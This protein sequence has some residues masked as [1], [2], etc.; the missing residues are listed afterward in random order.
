[1]TQ[2]SSKN[3][4]PKPLVLIILEGWGVAPFHPG[5]AISEAQPAYFNYLLSHYP[6]MTLEAS[7]PAVG[8]VAGQPVTSEDGYALI[9]SGRPRLS[10]QRLVDEHLAKGQ[11]ASA[12]ALLEAFARP[13]RRVHLIGSLSPA[14]REAVPAHLEALIEAVS[15]LGAGEIVLHAILDGR[16]AAP[17]AGRGALAGWEERL[18]GANGRIGSLSGSFYALDP[19]RNPDRLAR[20][21]EAIAFGRGNQAEAAMPIIEENYAKKI[22]DEEFPPTVISGAQPAGIAAADAVIFFNFHALPMQGLAS[23]L[24]AVLPESVARLS[25]VEYGVPGFLPL[26]GAPADQPCLGSLLA[27]AGLRQLRISDSEGFPGVTAFLD[28]GRRQLPG[29]AD[30]QIIPTPVLDDYRSEPGV[31]NSEIAK[32]TVKA[33]EEKK[34]DLIAVSFASIDRLAHSADL[35]ATVDSVRSVDS[36]LERIVTAALAAGGAAVIT[37]THG[38]A[39]QTITPADESFS[40]HTGRFVPLVLAVSQLEGLSLGLQQPIDGDLS[41][42]APAGTLCDVAPTVLRLLHMPVPEPMTGHSLY[43]PHASV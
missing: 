19:Y 36:S 30:W 18:A 9:G 12:P 29:A 8:L 21:A 34:Y 43:D 4:R 20:V 6:A 17:T 22:F 37:A 25:L 15:A 16:D 7:G 13:G 38:L 33:I 26:C 11:L 35:A 32:Q 2:P 24:S 28:D 31:V 5:N 14:E 39:E 42:L 23:A 1:M 40:A 3:H 10:A 27:D 41:L